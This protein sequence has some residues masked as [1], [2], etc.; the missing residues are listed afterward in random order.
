MELIGIPECIFEPEEEIFY[1]KDDSKIVQFYKNKCVL[2]TGATGFFGKLIVEKLLR[3]CTDIDTI[4][5]VVREKKGKNVQVRIDELY[6]D[7]VNSIFTNASRKLSVNERKE[8]GFSIF[9]KGSLTTR[10]YIAK[11][12]T[13]HQ[14]MILLHS[15]GVEIIDCRVRS[16]ELKPFS[17]NIH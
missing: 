12:H 14:S 16:P 15:F 1:S 9:V 10:Q 3:S 13:S 4:F 6:N 7:Q 8:N 2:V 17:I 5:I 11:L